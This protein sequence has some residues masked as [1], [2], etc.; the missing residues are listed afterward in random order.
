[1]AGPERPHFGLFPITDEILHFGDRPGVM[2]PRGCVLVVPRP[3]LHSSLRWSRAE[4]ARVATRSTE[5]SA[6]ERYADEPRP[7]LASVSIG[8]LAH[9][10]RKLGS[11]LENVF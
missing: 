9:T 7:A 11:T 3:V 1:M 10:V 2:Y 4:F 5:V 6:A 8:G